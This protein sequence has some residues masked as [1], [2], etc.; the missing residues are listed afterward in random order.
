MNLLRFNWSSFFGECGSTTSSISHNIYSI[1][2]H[3]ETTNRRHRGHYCR[4]VVSIFTLWLEIV[5]HRGLFLVLVLF[6]RLSS[7]N[8]PSTPTI[9]KKIKKWLVGSSFQ[10]GFLSFFF[11]FLPPVYDAKSTHLSWIAKTKRTNTMQIKNLRFIIMFVMQDRRWKKWPEVG[12]KKKIK[13]LG[14]L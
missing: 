3:V 5:S 12:M 1:K 2:W 9:T 8:T 10:S 13:L 14:W 4:I 7:Y 11:F 6:W